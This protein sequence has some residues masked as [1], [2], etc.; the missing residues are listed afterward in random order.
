MHA[1]TETVWDPLVRVGHWLL[2]ALFAAS[3]LSG[4]EGGRLHIWSG[5]AMPVRTTPK[6]R[7]IT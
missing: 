4:E 7:A 6:G 1:S 3:Y 5:Y 2:A